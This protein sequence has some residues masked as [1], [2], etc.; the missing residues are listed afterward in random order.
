M[1]LSLPSSSSWAN[2]ASNPISDASV[3]N[4]NDLSK[5]GCALIGSLVSF[6]LRLS[7]AVC[8]AGPQ[9]SGVS[10]FS[11]SYIGPAP[12]AWSFTYWRQDHADPKG[13]RHRLGEDLKHAL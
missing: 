11:I 2:T 1:T 8:L 7:K 4:L 9:Y 12:S 13:A 6:S 3:Y 10:L 5:F